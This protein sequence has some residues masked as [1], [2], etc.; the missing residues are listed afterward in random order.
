MRDAL[1]QASVAD[2]GERPMVDDRMVRPVEFV[3]QQPFRQRHA[4]GVGKTLSEGTGCGLH[5]RRHPDLGMTGRSRTELTEPFQLLDRQVIAGEIQKRV[6]QHRPVAIRQ[7][8]TVAIRPSRIRWV[9]TK[10]LPP[11]YLGDIG[12]PHG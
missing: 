5:T 6:E 8:K 12:H 3:G 10:I 2:E 7:N 11:Q 1:H 9:V 4:D